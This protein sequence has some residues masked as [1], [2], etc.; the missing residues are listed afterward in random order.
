MLS[1]SW[2]SGLVVAE[3]GETLTFNRESIDPTRGELKVD[4]LAPLI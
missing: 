3:K 2:P 1:I 4:N